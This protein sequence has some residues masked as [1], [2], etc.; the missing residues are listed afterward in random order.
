LYRKERVELYTIVKII[1]KLEFL[2]PSPYS[3][4]STCQVC[5][6]TP[7]HQIKEE[8]EGQRREALLHGMGMSWA[9]SISVH[10]QPSSGIHI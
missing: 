5:L 8:G 9:D 1:L 2:M 3:W 4:E 10:L 7:I 6:L